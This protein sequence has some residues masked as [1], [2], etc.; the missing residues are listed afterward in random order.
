LD[1]FVEAL[2]EAGA[3]TFLE[4]SRPPCYGPEFTEVG[5]KLPGGKGVANPIAAILSAGMMLEW[6]GAAEEA[7]RIQRAVSEVVSESRV[8]TPDMGGSSGTM[9]L[10]AAVCEKL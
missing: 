9:A 10:S 4:G 7:K 2:E 5:Q 8:R 6:L 1:R 3:I